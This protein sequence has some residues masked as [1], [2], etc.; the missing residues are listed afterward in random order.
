MFDIKNTMLVIVL[1]LG[2]NLT[3]CDVKKIMYNALCVQ[4]IHCK[5]GVC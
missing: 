2:Q 4:Y 1:L 3:I 5:G